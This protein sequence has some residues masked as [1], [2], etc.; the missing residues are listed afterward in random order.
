ML[1]TEG[2]SPTD[3]FVHSVEL[4]PGIFRREGSAETE[5]FNR[6]VETALTRLPARWETPV[7]VERQLPAGNGLVPTG[8]IPEDVRTVHADGPAGHVPMRVIS[9]SEAPDGVYLHL[10]GG[11]FCLGR[12]ENHDGMLYETA[13]AANVATV[14]VD[15]RLAPENPYPAGPAD[16]EAAALWVIENSVELFGTDKIVI[17]GES[18]GAV[19]AAV[20][21]LRLRDRHGYKDLAGLNLSQ[22]AFDLRFTPGVRA[23]GSRRL[24]LNTETVRCHIGRYLDGTGADRESP[25]VSPIFADLSDLP[26]ALFTVGTM[27]P[28]ID[29]NTYMYMRWITAGSPARLDV[30][31][32]AIHG[33]NLFDTQLGADA[34]KRT[35]AFISEVI[36][37]QTTRTPYARSAPS[38]IA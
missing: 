7:E 33:F 23:F 26:R 8:E 20:T 6:T 25:D 9:P 11:G 2:N 31:P 14:S 10:H 28:L 3:A 36:R 17:G 22:G 38:H 35:N 21:A 29:D 30:Y 18:A 37:L 15:Y 5:A 27:D 1:P 32:G 16:C 12:P 4:D 13:L 34:R 24:I 19:L